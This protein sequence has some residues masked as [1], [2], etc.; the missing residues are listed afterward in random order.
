MKYA[1][2]WVYLRFYNYIRHIKN[3]VRLIGRS[4]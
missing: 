2:E 1:I 3:I 4:K